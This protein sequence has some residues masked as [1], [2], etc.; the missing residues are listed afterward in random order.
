MRLLTVFV[1]FPLLGL[2]IHA[3]VSM[4]A[5]AARSV[6]EDAGDSRYRYADDRIWARRLLIRELEQAALQAPRDLSVLDRLGE[7]YYQA[8]FM[9]LART[10]FERALA[11]DSSDANAY[12]GLGRICVREGLDT[13][14]SDAFNQAERHFEHAVHARPQFSEA[15]VALAS[16]RF[17]RRDP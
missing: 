12:F 15:W 13:P 9:H 2:G 4:A 1:I 6:R 16:L 7:A 8:R 5:P 17:E 10:A 3:D 14:G 11:V